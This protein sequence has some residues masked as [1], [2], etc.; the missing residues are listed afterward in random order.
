MAP[1]T[2]STRREYRCSS[3]GVLEFHFLQLLFHSDPAF[4]A[5]E[6]LTALPLK[7]SS[8]I[9]AFLKKGM[10]LHDDGKLTQDELKA[11]AEY[12]AAL[13]EEDSSI[14]AGFL[15]S[16]L[17]SDELNLLL[18]FINTHSGLSPQ[19]KAKLK[20]DC[21]LAAIR[22]LRCLLLNEPSELLT[23]EF[24]E[25]AGQCPPLPELIEVA[26]ELIL[27]LPKLNNFS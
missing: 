21:P 24:I 15:S 16:G 20:E 23:A 1:V 26:S 4:I 3:S 8:F 13:V 11:A 22:L 19:L 14:K 25:Y 27:I 18:A 7:L 6:A 2:L 5:D 17:S 10:V 9:E 12:L